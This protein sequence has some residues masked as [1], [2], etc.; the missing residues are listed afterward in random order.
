MRSCFAP[1]T[2]AFSQTI[3]VVD[4]NFPA[5]AISRKTVHSQVVLLQ[6][7]SLPEALEAIA[8]H[9]PIESVDEEGVVV[10]LPPS[11]LELPPLG[12]EVHSDGMEALR[13][14]CGP[15]CTVT[16]ELRRDEFYERARD[17]YAIVQC[18]ERRPYG[19]FLLTCG[20]IGPDGREF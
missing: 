3:A 19:N 8:T 2:L 13:A 1:S 9:L 11:D 7:A 14:T 15:E 16:T 12:V 17:A 4:A 20:M 10:M 18:G 5:D 6:G